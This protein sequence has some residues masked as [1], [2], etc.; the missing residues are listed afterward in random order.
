MA[1]SSAGSEP[2][3][4]RARHWR[5]HGSCWFCKPPT[6]AWAPAW[7]RAPANRAK[8]DRQS[9]DRSYAPLPIRDWS[10]ARDKS[11]LEVR[12][13]AVRTRSLRISEAGAKWLDV[14]PIRKASFFRGSLEILMSCSGQQ[15]LDRTAQGHQGGLPICRRSSREIPTSSS[16]RSSNEAR[17]LYTWRRESQIHTA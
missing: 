11:V 3:R 5:F 14:E 1:F 4:W 7:Q 12:V 16:R 13:A 10:S 8:A 17:F 6:A 9:T 2:T 15:P